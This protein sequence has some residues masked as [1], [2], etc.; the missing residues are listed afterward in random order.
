V[1]NGAVESGGQL[2]FGESAQRLNQSV[3]G[4]QFG[5]TGVATGEVLRNAAGQDSWQFTV[6]ILGHQRL[7]LFAAHRFFLR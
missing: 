2:F 3:E 5:G 1:D 6:C 7:D 4:A